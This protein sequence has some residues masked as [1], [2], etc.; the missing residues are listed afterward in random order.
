ML[1]HEEMLGL[2]AEKHELIDAFNL[3]TKEEYVLHL[4]H[5]FPYTLVANLAKNMVVLDLGCNTGYGSEILS[6][7]AQKVV[8]VD[9][10]ENA[11]SISQKQYGHLN[12]D[13]HLIDGKKLPFE[14][15]TFDIIISCQV[16]EHIVDYNIYINELKRVLSPSGVVFFTTPNANLRLDPGMKP[17]NQFHVR[18]FNHSEL[19]NLLNEYFSSVKTMGL[20]TEK[21]LADIE[22]NRINKSKEFA[23]ISQQLLVTN[24]QLSFKLIVKK[25]LPKVV[26]EKFRNMRNSKSERNQMIDENF[27]K[28]YGFEDLNY[29]TNNQSNALD[30]LAICTNDDKFL[31]EM[32][33]KTSI[34]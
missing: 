14:D 24:K 28:K 10:S 3:K 11:I 21:E 13:F 31:E 4:I 17:W 2:Q 30:L 16:I 6:K 22:I 27:T 34:S 33:K 19:L 8:G 26:L 9:V 7:K 18:E 15:N 5:S 20:N 32:V 1:T 25:W 23:R 29:Q 12:I